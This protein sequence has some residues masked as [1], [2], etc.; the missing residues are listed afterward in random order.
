MPD[1]EKDHERLQGCI[2]D[3]EDA[4]GVLAKAHGET[5]TPLRERL[6]VL[7]AL[8]R[9]NGRPGL[10]TIIERNTT[11][12]EGLSKRLDKLENTGSVKSAQAKDRRSTITLIIMG[13]A[14]LLSFAFNLI[15]VLN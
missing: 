6:L 13:C 11:L 15:E 3:L 2:D 5:V 14:F 7:E 4:V 1:N 9:G 12:V 8:V 10:M